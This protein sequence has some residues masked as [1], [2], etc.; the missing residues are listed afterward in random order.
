MTDESSG[1]WNGL[2][3]GCRTDQCDISVEAVLRAMSDDRGGSRPFFAAA[4]DG[5]RYWVK[6][7]QNPG[8]SETYPEQVG[9]SAR[10]AGRS[11]ENGPAAGGTAVRGLD[12]VT[13]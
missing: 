6:Q 3:V 4:T 9:I 11:R 10:P 8:D 5:E 2:L 12:G 7:G 1:I 13:V